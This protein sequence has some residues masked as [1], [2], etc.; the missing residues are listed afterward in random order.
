VADQREAAGTAGGAGIKPHWRWFL[1]GVGA[2][3]AI[4]L[5]AFIFVSYQMPELLLDWS[6]L[7]YCG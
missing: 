7:R 5:L 1:A 6:N 4:L 3:L 2:A